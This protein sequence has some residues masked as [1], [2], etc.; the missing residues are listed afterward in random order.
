MPNPP[1]WLHQFADAVAAQLC[2]VD[3]LAPIGCHVFRAPEHWEVTLFVSATEVVGGRQ[4]GR[5]RTSRFFLD[6][7]ALSQ[8]FDVVR[9]VVW[10]AQGLG[11]GDDVGPHL[12]VEGDY[13]GHPVWLRVPATAPHV[14]PA[15]RQAHVHHQT[16]E[17]VW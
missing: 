14:F 9:S 15:G 7:Q 16:W 2:G 1:E 11:A 8:I 3:V 10:Q 12:A 13:C 17:E 4:D 5:Q 6:V